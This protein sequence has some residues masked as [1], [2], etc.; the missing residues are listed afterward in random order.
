M[1]LFQGTFLQAAESE[2]NGV[3]TL[4]RNFAPGNYVLEVYEYSNTQVTPRG[5]T[6]FTVQ[7]NPS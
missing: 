2:A 1:Q 6:C 5:R 7:V 4:T 3:E